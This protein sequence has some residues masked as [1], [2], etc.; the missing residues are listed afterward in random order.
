MKKPNLN[1]KSIKEVLFKDHAPRYHTHGILEKTFFFLT[2]ILCF[3]ACNKTELR[4]AIE[5]AT[6]TSSSSPL[7]TSALTSTDQIK[8][9]SFNVRGNSASDP[10][11]MEQRQGN[12]RQ[13]IV[14]NTPDV[15]GLQEFSENNFENWFMPQMATLGYSVYFN[16]SAGLGSP[17]VIFYKTSRFTLQSSGT[18]LIDPL[19]TGTWVILLDNVN[20]N[21][22]FFCN[23]HWSPE[24]NNNERITNAQAVITAVQTNNPDGLP[25]VV[26][27]DFNSA[28]GTTQI[29]NLK[30]ALGVADALGDSDGDPTFHGWD[31]T[32]DAKIDWLM[33]NKSFAYTSFQVITT[34]YG[35]F[36]PSDHWP[37]MAT[38]IPAIFGAP[39]TDT[40]GLSANPNTKFFFADVNGD[41]KK[42]KIYWN[43][44]F[45]GGKPQIFLSNGDG[46]FATTAVAHAAGASALTTTRYYY[47]DIDGDGKADEI[48]WDPTLNSGKTMVY[49]ATGSGNFSATAI[50][51]TQGTSAGT[52]TTYYF[53]DVN[54]DGKADKVYWNG[55]VDSGHTRIYLATSGG[56]FSNTVISNTDAGMSTTGGTLF[57]FADVNGDGKADKIMWQPTLSSGKPMV[58]LSNGDGTFTASSTFSNSGA[59]SASAGTTFYFADVNGDGRADKIYWNPGNYSGKIKVYYSQA[60]NVFDGPVYSLWG[61]SASSSTYFYF[62]DINGDGKPD[63]IRWNYGEAS[64]A[65]SNYFAK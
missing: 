33:C 9:M 43:S 14:D 22:Y 19:R 7:R 26:F 20:S 5:P 27:G 48:L 54:G 49:L 57:Y 46:T 17:K 36:W 50:N 8:V 55:T 35:G 10:Q 65:L 12:I 53:D 52:T 47:A 23:S 18:F 1:Q 11:T 30:N 39:H 59:S 6:P 58:Y 2:V 4:K 44:T 24:A 63:Q 28:P 3:S 40:H 45:D 29:S 51:N 60:T 34:S 64:G 56:F 16:E 13:I 42:D 31:A 25:E 21:K 15:F 61:L 38:F 41:G 37:V 62:A 32:G